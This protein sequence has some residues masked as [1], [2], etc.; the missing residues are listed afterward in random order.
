MYYEVLTKEGLIL[1]PRSIHWKNVYKHEFVPYMHLCGIPWREADDEEDA[2][3]VNVDSS[4]SGSISV[5]YKGREK[6]LKQLGEEKLGE[7]K[8]FKFKSR[9]KHSAYKECTDCQRLRLAI[10]LAIEQRLSISRIKQLQEEYASHL[11]WMMRQR[12]ELERIVQMA[13]NERM[14]VE[15]SDKCGDSCLHCPTPGG[16]VCSANTSL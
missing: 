13:T 1:Y 5:W 7:G 3:E 11:Q 9:V 4:A 16:R 10:Q 12:R 15:N 8:C 2:E 6:A 14:L